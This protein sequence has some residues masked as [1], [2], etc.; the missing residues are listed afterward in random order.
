MLARRNF[1][2]LLPRYSVGAGAAR[3]RIAAQSGRRLTGIQFIASER[4]L[5]AGQQRRGEKQSLY[6]AGGQA[7]PGRSLFSRQYRERPGVLGV[8]AKSAVHVR[9]IILHA[10]PNST[11]FKIKMNHFQALLQAVLAED[12]VN[13]Y[14]ARM[15]PGGP[16]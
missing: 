16:A 10:F 2:S 3:L 1:G 5:K 9:R 8:C 15:G 14:S 12:C 7:D 6:L 11:K 4:K 13:R